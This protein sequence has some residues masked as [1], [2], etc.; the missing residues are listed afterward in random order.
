M[1]V[2]TREN[3]FDPLLKTLHQ[4]GGSASNSEIE[5]KIT[6]ILNLT[7]KETSEIHRGNRTK[8]SYNLAWARTY[9]KLYGLI[10]RSARGIWALTSK[11]KKTESVDE[12]EVTRHARELGYG[13]TVSEKEVIEERE[14]K[15]EE[16]PWQDQ[17]LE[18]I[19]KLSSDAF[20]RL[21]QRVL[22]ESGLIQVK[23]TGRSGD[24]GVDGKGILRIAGLLTFPVIFQC[25]RYTGRVSVREIRDFRG[26]MAGR[27]EKGLF[28]TTGTFT[29]DA[30]QEAT[31]EGVPPIDLIDG[32]MLVNK[33]KELGLGIII[34]NEEVVEIN[35][36]WFKDF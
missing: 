4:L 7:E 18:E 35:K 36:E 20:E 29:L 11:G 22:R 21:C 32:E 30:R 5:E 26:A 12:E 33:M 31:R 3:L 2:P 14:I 15:E 23:V 10:E 24:G 34:K 1:A 6:E 25:K 8:L 13:N 16:S 27:A 28:I 19:M 17:A 9:L